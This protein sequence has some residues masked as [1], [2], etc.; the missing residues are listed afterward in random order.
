MPK[1][2]LRTTTARFNLDIAAKADSSQFPACFDL[3]A[4]MKKNGVSPNLSTY[5]TLLRALAHGGYAV[6]TLAV[7]EDMLSVGVSPDATSFNHIIHAHRTEPTSLLPFVLR[8]MEEVG[9][10]PNATTFTHL[11]TRFASDENLEVALQ[12]LHAMKAHNLLPEIAAAQAVIILAA[13]QG[14]PRLALDLV[15]AFEAESIRKV[16]DFVWLACLHSSA[17]NLYADGVLKSWYALVTDLAISPDEGLCTLVLHTAARNGL[18]DL[19][20]DALRVLKVLE[21]PWME[22]HLA[23]LF[24]AFCRAQRFQEAFST[25]TVMRQ[26][27]IDPT[28]H[29]A[30]PIIQVVENNPD[31][32]DDLWA[33]L[34]NMHQDGISVDI[35]A[36]NALLRASRSTQPIT[37]V[38]ADYNTLKSCG[39]VPSAETFHLFIDVCISAGNIAYG[40][41]A[42]R[43]FKEVG[44]PDHDVFGKMVILHLTQDVYDEAFLYLEEMHSAGHVP[45]QHLYEAIVIKC[46]TMGDA[47]YV[48]AL[49]EMR[50]VGHTIDPEFSFHATELNDR[51]L[52]AEK[53]AAERARVEALRGVEIDGAARKFIETGGLS[54]LEE[55]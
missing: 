22:Y 19:A 39:L 6:A 26:N 27:N 48:V 50:D 20:T 31:I 33:I 3:A 43:Q 8:K 47:R 38:L 9:V 28:S 29:T 4:D 5:N 46:A 45:A 35:S 10:A 15:I 24:E 42:F 25:L 30:F 37:R 2:Q 44:T 41:L 40:E 55:K 7:L 51:A 36:F 11:I 16:E 53:A 18:P 52:A 1:T 13:K 54:G 32:L 34:T 23:P 12:H 21:V 49:D 17:T 14:Y